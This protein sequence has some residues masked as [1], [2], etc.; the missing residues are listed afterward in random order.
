MKISSYTEICKIDSMT[1]HKTEGFSILFKEYSDAGLWVVVT[2][3]KTSEKKEISIKELWK[4]LY[5][6][7]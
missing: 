2:N 1:E 6:N 4:L 3:K 5:E 7:R